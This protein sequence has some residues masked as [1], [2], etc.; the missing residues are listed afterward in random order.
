MNM[1]CSTIDWF[2]LNFGKVCRKIGI[3][4]L[5]A[6]KLAI[7]AKKKKKV[8]INVNK[9]LS[10]Y[11]VKSD[12]KATILRDKSWNVVKKFDLQIIIPAFNSEKYIQECV[13]SIINQKCDYMWQM[14]VV[15][16]GSTDRTLEILKRYLVDER[17]VVISQKNQGAA[18]ARNKGIENVSSKYLMF[19]DSDDILEPGA[20]QKLM[21]CAYRNDVDVVEGNFYDWKNGKK[22]QASFS[23][24]AVVTDPI[25]Q[26][27]GFPCGKV[28]RT[29]LFKKIQFPKGF[30]FEDSIISFL[31]LPQVHI[32]WTIE[33][34]VFAYRR[35]EMS[36]TYRT[37]KNIKSVDTCYILN[38]MYEAADIL[39]I[40]IIQLYDLSLSHI[41]LSYE[42]IS[43]FNREIRECCFCY[44]CRVVNEKFRNISSKR[45]EL[46]NIDVAIKDYNF[47]LYEIIGRFE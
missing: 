22:R 6:S 44:F 18:A 40:D 41:K 35:F 3:G 43:K 2:F 5:I 10:L 14:I 46:K 11:S 34:V 45:K 15:D 38:E 25:N 12:G 42:R 21:Q 17:I 33:D 24:T 29:E 39:G 47:Q 19:V 4:Q 13:E 32:A 31:I 26:L 1:E 37:K 30:L 16:D 8:V 9:D 36:T 7:R 23:K 27:L 28:F 20:I